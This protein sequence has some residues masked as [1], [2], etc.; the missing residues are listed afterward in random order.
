[1]YHIS[2]EMAGIHLRY[3]CDAFHK[4]LCDFENNG[5]HFGPRV[6]G[7][8]PTS[9]TTAMH[10]ITCTS[11]SI[12]HVPRCNN[13]C[14]SLQLMLRHICDSFHNKK[15]E[16][17]QSVILYMQQLVQVAHLQLNSQGHK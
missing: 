6:I 3:I 12:V 5:H 8:E 16:L 11:K 2:S 15:H 10:P 1:M 9:G 7:C 13:F 17:E 14:E 4:K